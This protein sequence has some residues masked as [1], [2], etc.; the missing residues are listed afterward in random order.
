MTFTFTGTANGGSPLTF[1]CSLSGP[2]SVP[3]QTCDAATGWTNPT[4]L[5]AGA[6]TF[7]LIPVTPHLLVDAEPQVWE[8]VVVD[9]TDPQTTIVDGPNVGPAPDLASGP[10]AAFVFA[11]NEADSTFE[12]SFDAT[13]WDGCSATQEYSSLAPVRRRCQRPR[14]RPVGQ[15][16]RDAGVAH[17]DRVRPAGDDDRPAGPAGDD[18]RADGDVRLLVRPDRRDVR[19]LARTAPCSS[20]APRR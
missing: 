13:T 9:E 18:D 14:H 12:C 17:V 8:F 7:E 2:V 11:S 5:A 4:P 19:V 16:R 20:T 1:Q 15:R 10:L 6:Y 3:L